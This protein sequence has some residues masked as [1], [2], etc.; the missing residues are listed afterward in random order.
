MMPGVLGVLYCCDIARRVGKEGKD[1][2]TRPGPR[3]K[4]RVFR[5]EACVV[6]IEGSGWVGCS[7]LAIVAVSQPHCQSMCCLVDMVNCAGYSPRI[8]KGIGI[9]SNSLRPAL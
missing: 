3:P 6:E 5:M 2:S 4:R 8:K 9:E 7:R 1:G